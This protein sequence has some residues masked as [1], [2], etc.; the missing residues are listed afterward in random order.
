MGIILTLLIALFGN[1]G[2]VID[3]NSYIVKQDEKSIVIDGNSY[4]TTN[5][6]NTNAR[7]VIDGNSF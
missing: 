5:N 3:G 2:I 6:A 1:S 4:L 7:I